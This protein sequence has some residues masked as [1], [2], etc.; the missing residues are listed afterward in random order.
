MKEVH[1]FQRLLFRNCSVTTLMFP[2]KFEVLDLS[3]GPKV[4][5]RKGDI[6]TEVGITSQVGHIDNPAIF[7]HRL[8]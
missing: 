5:K 3:I 4:A 2:A 8:I 6:Q 7:N 1:K